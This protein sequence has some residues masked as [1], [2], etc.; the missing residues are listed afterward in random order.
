MFPS[1]ARAYSTQLHI[2]RWPRSFGRASFPVALRVP[3]ALRLF[4][5][6]VYMIELSLLQP[7]PIVTNQK[8]W[9]QTKQFRTW[10]LSKREYM[11]NVHYVARVVL[12]CFNSFCTIMSQFMKH[13]QN[14]YTFEMLWFVGWRIRHVLKD[15]SRPPDFSWW[16]NGLWHGALIV[17]FHI[18]RQGVTLTGKLLE[19]KKKLNQIPDYA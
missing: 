10:I 6:Y 13:I 19:S 4:V 12:W 7:L 14:L 5:S 3:R 9:L 15:R 1:P 18:T 16:E 17:R 2:H 11:G 8:L